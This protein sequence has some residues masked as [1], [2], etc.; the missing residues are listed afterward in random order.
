MPINI[1]SSLDTTNS[2]IPLITPGA[3]AKLPQVSFS[4][5]DNTA[6][7]A[8]AALD[9][10]SNPVYPLTDGQLVRTNSDNVWHKWV[11]ASKSFVTV[12]ADNVFGASGVSHAP[13]I[14]PDP[15]AV[16]GTT[17]YLREDGTWATPAGGGGSAPGGTNGQFQINN[18]GALGGVSITGD[19]AVAST[20]VSTLANVVTAGTSPK[21]TYDAKGRVTGGTAL[22]AADLPLFVASGASHAAGAVPDPG[23]V[24][25]T[26]KYLREDGTWTVPPS[27]STPGGTN[28]QFQVNNA[29]A[30]GGVTFSGDATVTSA[31]VVTLASVATAGTSSKVTFD[32]KGR[33]TAGAALTGADLPVFVASGASHAPGA[34][35]DPG[36][37]A[38]TTKFLREDGTWQVPVGGT[39]SPAGTSG[40]V[41][42]NNA[43]AFGGITLSGDATMNASGVV[44]LSNVGTAGTTGS[45]SLIP[46]ITT[47]AKGRVTGVTTAA[48]AI[49]TVALPANLPASSFVGDRRIVSSDYPGFVRNWNGTV[50]EIIGTGTAIAPTQTKNQILTAAAAMGTFKVGTRVYIDSSQLDVDA[51]NY[52]DTDWRWDGAA[53]V[54]LPVAALPN[55]IVANII[56]RTNILSQL[57]TLTGNV[58]ELSSA[59]DTPAI[60]QTYATGG[61]TYRPFNTVKSVTAIASQ[62]VS[63]DADVIELT[64]NPPGAA[65]AITITIG[66][67]AIAGQAVTVALVASN[68]NLSTLTINDTHG[69]SR[70]MAPAGLASLPG[71]NFAAYSMTLRWTGAAW[72]AISQNTKSIATAFT[73]ANSFG[74]NNYAGNNYTFAVGYKNIASGQYAVAFG[75]NNRSTGSGIVA[76]TENRCTSM[77]A[78]MG[79]QSEALGLTNSST[80]AFGAAAMAT[81]PGSFAINAGRAGVRFSAVVTGAASPFTAT[82][83]LNGLDGDYTRLISNGTQVHLTIPPSAGVIEPGASV[84]GTVA[85][86]TFNGTATSFTVTSLAIPGGP[87]NAATNAPLVTAANVGVKGVNS[88]VTGTGDAKILYDGERAVGI[89]AFRQLSEFFLYAD[90]VDNT[91]TPLTQNGAAAAGTVA[92]VSTTNRIIIPINHRYAITA[93]IF[94]TDQL[95]NGNFARF[96]KSFVIQ[97]TNGVVTVSAVN[98]DVPFLNVGTTLTTNSIAITADNTNKALS[99]V[100]TGGAASFYQVTASLTALIHQI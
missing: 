59:T 32:A 12:T 29:G 63:A 17:K 33:V 9:V 4:V 70:S 52:N 76:G 60:V 5:A 88:F 61:V 43:G 10:S 55:T 2:A 15:G 31:G 68:A 1:S 35:P 40:Q 77:G 97:D 67:G 85:G 42:I 30:L 19:V 90:T 39:A 58:G 96:R 98:D 82:I 54:Q 64:I 74:Y 89:G 47:D 95:Q 53:F 92:H 26:T 94:V 18:A 44:T 22:V 27:G 91:P 8:L 24:A 93:D 49:T 62:T 99:I 65:S 51:I 80:F 50:W 23:A 36:V 14:V 41:Q 83:K 37:T 38:G 25:G 81:A 57:V 100:F 69:F 7:A 11:S 56:P 3:A 71:A 6:L 72:E 20:G 45:Q 84:S 79:S 73:F 28:G 21:V 78:A 46:V 13:G 87:T 48:A 75:N 34:V 86:L 16:A 66:D